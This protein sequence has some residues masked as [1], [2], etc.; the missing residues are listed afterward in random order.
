[1]TKETTE[2]TIESLRENFRQNDFSSRE[3][4]YD[5]TN[6]VDAKNRIYIKAKEL[7]SKS[8]NEQ[9][10]ALAGLASLRGYSGNAPIACV[11]ESE[12]KLVAGTVMEIL[13]DGTLCESIITQ[14]MTDMKAPLFEEA[15]QYAK[16]HEKSVNKLTDTEL[17]AIIDQF[18]DE[19]LSRM[20]NLLLQVQNIPELVTLA[21][22]MPTEEDFTNKCANFKYLDYRRYWYHTRT[23]FGEMV[24]L[25]DF[26]EDTI[27]DPE[28]GELV[29]N[30]DIGSDWIAKRINEKYEE[31]QYD[32][33]YSIF[34]SM[35]DSVDQQILRM[36]E[37]KL[38]QK[39]IADEL[40][41]KTASAVSKRMEK[42][43]EKFEMLIKSIEN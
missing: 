28:T 6:A 4:T 30:P 17:D 32:R 22:K 16:K 5:Y 38:T 34:H 9:M 40:G 43:R 29:D 21:K 18:A 37:Y 41:F 7:F 24:S 3:S 11:E 1:M 15:Q 36:R 20:M 31:E 19:F 14:I 33:L 12:E 42:M 2:L 10:K 39:E 27:E 23:K 35:L 26:P 8:W 13:E 25:D